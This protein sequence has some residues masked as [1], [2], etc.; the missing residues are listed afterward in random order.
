MLLRFSVSNY[1]SIRSEQELSLVAGRGK[2]PDHAHRFP[3]GSQSV[4]PSAVIYGANAAGK[5]NMIAALSFMRSAVLWSH[6]RWEPDEGIPR[7]HFALDDSAQT[8]PSLLDLEFEIE[9][10]RYH[11]GF[12][13]T[14]EEFVAE[15]LYYYPEG[16]R[17]R[18]FER[19]NGEVDFGADFKGQKKSLQENMRNNSLLISVSSQNDVDIIKPVRAYFRDLKNIS[20]IAIGS[21]EVNHQF[22]EEALDDRV[23][24]FLGDVGTGVVSSKIIRS[25]ADDESIK[26]AKEFGDFMAKQAG[27]DVTGSDFVDFMSKR[28]EVQLG[29]RTRSGEA[30]FLDLDWESA[31]TRR[32]LPVVTAAYQA[33]DKG[34]LL[35]IDEIDASLHTHAAESLFAL[36]DDPELNRHGAQLIATVHDTNLLG[37]EFLQRDQI[38]LVEKNPF[39]E[40]EIYSLAEIKSRSS[41]NFEL[42]YLQGRY[43]ATI[44]RPTRRPRF[45]TQSAPA[46]GDGE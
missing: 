27:S 25:E 24:K 43:G 21:R 7:R 36:F 16:S 4:V 31:G 3:F 19:K 37:S 30:Q 11:Y 41:D 39:G 28:T 45:L 9:G 26:F 13:A 33:L 23:V 18:L 5:S 8:E 15:W 17:R 46:Q 2:V 20:S 1:L 34:G 32:L 42:G 6:N 22:R 44:P 10:V 12:E 38:W 29:H 40:T 14:D 35:L